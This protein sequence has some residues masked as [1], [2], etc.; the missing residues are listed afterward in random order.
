METAR[1]QRERIHYDEFYAASLDGFQ[2]EERAFHIISGQESRPHNI[3]WDFMRAVQDARIAGKMVLDVGCG[4][5]LHTA[6]YAKLGARVF[7]FDVS[8][9]AIE[10]TRARLE[11]YGLSA[12]LAVMMAEQ[13]QYPDALFDLVFGVDV[14]HHV[15]VDAAAR[16]VSRVLKPG[17]FGLFLEWI[18]W[19]FFERIRNRPLVLKLF[20]HGGWRSEDRDIT[21]DEKK[22]GKRE[23]EALRKH[24]SRVTYKKFYFLNRLA[25]FFPSLGAVFEKT[26]RAVFRVFPPIENAA[27]AAIIKLRK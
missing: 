19:P 14:L 2:P 5:G 4:I 7:A 20:P 10:V 16:E 15:E 21:E 3:F 6:L 22:L 25:P 12:S 8:P 9:K 13:L 18:E 1:Q 27:A 24:F 11:H 17:G 23:D 26:D